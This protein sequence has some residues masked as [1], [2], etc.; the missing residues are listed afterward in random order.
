METRSKVGPTSQE[1]VQQE[2]IRR[3]EDQRR[4]GPDDMLGKFWKRFSGI[5]LVVV[6]SST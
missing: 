3:G 4:Q 2:K 6:R 5:I 1:K